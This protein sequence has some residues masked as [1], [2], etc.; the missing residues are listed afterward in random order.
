MP[1]TRTTETVFFPDEIRIF[2]DVDRKGGV[3]YRARFACRVE[4]SDGTRLDRETETALDP[5]LGDQIVAGLTS[6]VAGDEGVALSEDATTL[7]AAELAEAVAMA[8]FTENVSV[9]KE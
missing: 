5:V 8:A 4:L 2:R 3:T 6:P 1:K 9:R 7:T